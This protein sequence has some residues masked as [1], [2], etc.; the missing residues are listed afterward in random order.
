MFT[1][2]KWHP[3][4]LLIL[5]LGLALTACGGSSSSSGP[6]TIRF[7]GDIPAWPSNS[8]MI[9]AMQDH[10]KGKYNIQMIKV[11]WNN[12]DTVIKTGIISGNPAD[13]YFYW[14]AS[15]GNYV[16][17]H[18]AL[19]L[20]PYLEANNNAWKN[21]FVP[22]NLALGLYNGKYYGLP[23]DIA[24]NTILVNEDLAQKL[25]VTIPT[26]MSW[27]QFMSINQQITARAG[28]GVY[29]FGIQSGWIPWIPRDGLLSL[30]NDENKLDAYGSG[31]LPAT[32]PIFLKAL[33]N[34]G[35]LYNDNYVF[36]GGKSALTETA[37]Q[38]SAGFQQGKVVMMAEV[39]SLTQTAENLAKS[40][41]FK[42]AAVDW[43][44]M[45]SQ[46]IILGGC[47]G[48]FIPANAPHPQQ[49]AEVLQYYLG[50]DVQRIDASY[51][52]VPSNAEA[53]TSISD[54]VLKQ[55][56][57]NAGPF[58]PQELANI[59]PKIGLYFTNN[60]VQDYVLGESASSD[61]AKLNQLIQQATQSS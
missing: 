19:D 50:K 23:S 51:G 58:H 21:T 48:F 55:V 40:G 17:A 57:Q 49:A 39:F 20:T 18:E 22:S 15:V 25:G 31:H 53:Q 37:D 30:A 45:G 27:D 52:L 13:I 42:I 4:I 33:E 5:V 29:P 60:L 12:L 38:V 59:S 34:S 61:L 14:P 54:P 46:S 47:D 36:P 16:K 24:S 35:A 44:H 3:F 11:D 56:V 1:V 41:G 8:A 10:F 6:I 2:R 26:H 7:Y 9:K 43:P 28:N 32:D